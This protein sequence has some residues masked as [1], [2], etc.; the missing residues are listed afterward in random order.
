[1]HDDDKGVSL[2]YRPT[3]G[4]AFVGKTVWAIRWSYVRKDII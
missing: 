1:M 4:G 3:I 2:T